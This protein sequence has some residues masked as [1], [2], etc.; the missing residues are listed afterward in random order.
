M[1]SIFLL[2]N[3]FVIDI[4]LAMGHVDENG[5]LDPNYQSPM[6]IVVVVLVLLL[7]F[8]LSMFVIDL[9]YYFSVKR[10]SKKTGNNV[11]IKVKGDNEKEN[12]VINDAHAKFMTAGIVADITSQTAELDVEYQY[13]TNPSTK[14]S[15]TVALL[16]YV[17]FFPLLLSILA[18]ML[19]GIGLNLLVNLNNL[20][21]AVVPIII[22][23]SA[24]IGAFFLFFG[25]V[26]FRNNAAKKRAIKTTKECGIRIYSDYV[27]QYVVV[28]KGET[29]AEIDY[30][31]PFLKSKH[32][33]TKKALFIKGKNNGQVVAIRLNKSEMS[34]EALILIK[35]KLQK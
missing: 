26:I 24:S 11:A 9:I 27:E 17:L 5:V 7:I 25:I 15:E 6:T 28:Y 2:F 23:V 29:E 8:T 18:I 22:T 16:V 14:L 32:L 4:A 35:S 31:V 21:D 3:A 30:K 34:E 12:T 1:V 20:Q 10:R 33:E 13:K 19:L